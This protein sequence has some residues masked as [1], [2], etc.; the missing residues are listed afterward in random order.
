MRHP[1]PAIAFCAFLIS[2]SLEAFSQAVYIPKGYW[3]LQQAKDHEEYVRIQGNSGFLCVLDDKSSFR[4][5]IVGDSITTP[6]DRKDAIVWAPGSGDITISGE[7]KGEPY[8][9]RYRMTDSATYYAKCREEE[10]KIPVATLQ[11][12]SRLSAPAA[13]RK[14]RDALGRKPGRDRG[15]MSKPGPSGRL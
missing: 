4:F 13:A 3:K 5:T 11:R 10:A 7:E 6:W 9:T 1:A 2:A 15:R 8:S 14:D 12:P